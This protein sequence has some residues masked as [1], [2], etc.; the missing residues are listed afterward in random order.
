MKKISFIA[1]VLLIAACYWSGKPYRS[2]SV[3]ICQLG[4]EDGV[5]LQKVLLWDKS[6]AGNCHTLINGYDTFCI[7]ADEKLAK[8]D[9]LSLE[10]FKE[11]FNGYDLSNPMAIIHF[12]P[13]RY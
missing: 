4:K 7:K 10:D 1:I 6:I 3:T 2:S 5:G 13:F 9:G 8:N 12:T 11:W